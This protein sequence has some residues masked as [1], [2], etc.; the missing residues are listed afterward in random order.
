MAEFS[1]MP[2]MQ[3]YTKYMILLEI[4]RWLLIVIEHWT[5]WLVQDIVNLIIY[6]SV[7]GFTCSDANAKMKKEYCTCNHI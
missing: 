6:L 7:Y 4:K 3:E 1:R 2:S 5:T